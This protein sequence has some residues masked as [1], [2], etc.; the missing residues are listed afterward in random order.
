MESLRTGDANKLSFITEASFDYS[1]PERSY[2]ITVSDHD[3]TVYYI[4]LVS[5]T[6]NI[7]DHQLNSIADESRTTTQ[8]T[9]SASTSSIDESTTIVSRAP[10]SVFSLVASATN[11]TEPVSSAGV[12]TTSQGN[13][14]GGSRRNNADAIA[15]GLLG[16]LVFLIIVLTALVILRGRLR[17]RR[18]APSAQFMHIARRGDAGAGAPSKGGGTP[19]WFHADRLNGAATP[20]HD[21]LLSHA[22]L[23]ESAE[24]SSEGHPPPPGRDDRYYVYPTDPVLQK[25]REAAGTWELYRRRSESFATAHELSLHEDESEGHT[26]SAEDEKGGCA[27]A[28]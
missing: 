26:G 10:S 17:A 21:Q 12:S 20:V 14:S 15:G 28:L 24:S 2:D 5:T 3:N 7:S 8:E 18:T 6:Y 4:L 11:T 23:T 1:Q 19:E 9:W 25:A 27:F 16:G 22:H 13:S